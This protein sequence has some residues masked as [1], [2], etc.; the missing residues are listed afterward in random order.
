MDFSTPSLHGSPYFSA[1]VVD[2]IPELLEAT[3]RLRYQVYCLERRF[4]PA[5]EYPDQRET[6]AYDAHSVHVAVVN[7]SGEVAA[8]ARLIELTDA[9]LPLLNHCAL[10]LDVVPSSFVTGRVVEVSRLSVSRRYNRRAGDAYYAL[11]GAKFGITEEERRTSNRGGEIIMTLC[12][13]LYQAS[14]RSGY[15]HWLAATEKSLQRLI[16][17]YSLPFEPIGPEVD[18]YG[19]VTPYAMSVRRFDEV[20]L[21]GTVPLV[22]DFLRGL[23]PEFLPG[24]GE[25]PG[26]QRDGPRAG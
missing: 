22:S 18:Y 4:L 25:A 14:K 1:V 8:T 2:G 12:H 6:D 21:S 19:K 15:T 10:F 7:T 17:A 26:V 23:E 3:Y 5:A 13:A 24:S 9:G 16:A 11:A 20:I